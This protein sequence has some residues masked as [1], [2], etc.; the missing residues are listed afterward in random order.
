MILDVILDKQV[1]TLNESF[2]KIWE[3]H[4][5]QGYIL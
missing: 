1:F 5:E 2:I 3:F 4:L